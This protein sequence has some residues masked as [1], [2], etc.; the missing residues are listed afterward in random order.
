MI[1]LLEKLLLVDREY[2]V[3]FFC[4]WFLAVMKLQGQV[5]YTNVSVSE[6]SQYFPDTAMCLK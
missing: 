1:C 5:C 6:N 3:I 4:S 2:F